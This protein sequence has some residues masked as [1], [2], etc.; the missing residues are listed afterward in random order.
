LIQE[1]IGEFFA[2][3]G[4]MNEKWVANLGMNIPTT[5]A[6]FRTL[7]EAFRDRDPNRNGRRD[8]IPAA[9][10]T[11]GRGR[12]DDFLINAFIYN[13]TR[14]RLT[15]D[16]NGRVDVIYNKAEYR[17]ALRYI[18][19]LVRDGLILDQIYT[20]DGNG[21]RA[22]IESQ[23]VSTVGFFTAGLAGALSPNNQ[24]RLNTLR[25]RP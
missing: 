23:S 3:R 16:N 18:N 10:N 9:G 7:L 1:Q 11:T 21:L 8:E 20:L 15:V 4:W 13:D 5:T 22:I 19:G 14:D 6:E 2:L 12:I 24:M 17:E 25:W